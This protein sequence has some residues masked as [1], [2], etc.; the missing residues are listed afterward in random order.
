MDDREIQGDHTAAPSSWAEMDRRLYGRRV[1]RTMKPT[2]RALIDRLLPNYL[3]PTSRP[4][5]GP[6]SASVPGQRA[7]IAAIDDPRSLFPAP[8]RRVWL[9]IGFGGG[10]HLAA[11]AE[12]NPDTGIIGCEFF[13]DGVASLLSALDESRGAKTDAGAIANVRIHTDDAREVTDALPE[14]S[15]DRVFVLFPDPWPKKR[16]WRRRLVST[17]FLDR[18]AYLLADGGELR[19]A[20]DDRSYIRWMLSHATTHPAFDWTARRAA[21]WRSRPDDWPPTRYEAKAIAQGR[22]PAFLRFVRRNRAR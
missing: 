1:G 20:S 6:D 19:M 22:A 18:L 4:E 10:E 7:F 12:A 14:G 16:H 11:Q 13:M 3:I 5:P 21:D 2:R 17:P 9:E 15:L 8:V